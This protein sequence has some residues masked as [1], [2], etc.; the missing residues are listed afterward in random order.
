M[1]NLPSSYVATV[2]VKIKNSLFNRTTRIESEAV[3]VIAE[4]QKAI[5]APVIEYSNLI[6]P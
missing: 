1:D 3:T 2:Q 4:N 5:T 6:V